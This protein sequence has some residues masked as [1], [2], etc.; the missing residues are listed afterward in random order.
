LLSLF[1]IFIAI[2]DLL[3][4]CQDLLEKL[5]INQNLKLDSGISTMFEDM[6]MEVSMVGIAPP[7]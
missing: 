4:I 1:C 7:V 3:C 2:I 6:E 5:S